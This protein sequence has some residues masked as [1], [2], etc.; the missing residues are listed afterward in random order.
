MQMRHLHTFIGKWCPPTASTLFPLNLFCE[1]AQKSQVR[2]TQ[3]SNEPPPE[4][5]LTFGGCFLH[6]KF[7]GAKLAEERKKEGEQI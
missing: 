3:S 5:I 4:N 1:K 7:H 2:S 6:S